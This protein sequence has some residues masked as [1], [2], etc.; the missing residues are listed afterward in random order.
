M[1]NAMMRYLSMQDELR[2]KPRSWLVTGAAGFIGSNLIEKLLHLDQFVVGLDNFSTGKQNNLEQIRASVGMKAWDRFTY[3]T[4][5]ITDAA[6]CQRSVKDVDY[7]LHQA[8]LGSVPRSIADPL[9][10]HQSNVN[11]FL[12]MLDAARKAK[13]QRF[14]YASSSSVYGDS[15]DLPKVET[16]IGNPLSTYALTKSINEQYAAVYALN[17]GLS[18]IGLRYFNVFGRRQ[19]PQGVY[20]AVIPRWINDLSKGNP[21]LINGDGLTSRDFCYVANVVQ[22]NLLAATTVSHDA[23]NQVYNIAVSERTTLIDL[24]FAIRN[25]L[26]ALAPKYNNI[27]DLQPSYGPFRG[28]DIRHSLANIEKAKQLLGYMPTHT[29]VEGLSETLPWYIASSE[30]SIYA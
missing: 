16:K 19:D 28:G 10:T 20:A 18:T 17:Y 14:V 26:V 3:Y 8:A 30:M 1:N 5:D 27:R 4:G 21:C 7:V 29:L 13:V 2:A 12:Q 15:P 9:T 6:D 22:A 23:V 11:G 25:G 24:F